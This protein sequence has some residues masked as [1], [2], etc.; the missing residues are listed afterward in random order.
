MLET[1]PHHLNEFTKSCDQLKA[2]AAKLEFSPNQT[3]LIQQQSDS[4]KCYAVH[5]SS[6]DEDLTDSS[7]AGLYE[8]VLDVSFGSLLT[9]VR[10]N[11]VGG[12]QN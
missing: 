4:N 10:P 9:A 6:P 11:L 5:S 2:L 1:S 8:S 12:R 7:F 3:E